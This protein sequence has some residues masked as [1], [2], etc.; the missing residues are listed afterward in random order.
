MKETPLVSIITPL[1]NSAAF[2][3]DALV[4]V[5]NQQYQ[6]WEHIIIDDC[7]EDNSLEIVERFSGKDARFKLIQLSKNS[8]S[9]VARN[10]GIKIAK[11]KYIAFIDS[12]DVWKE[13][14]LERQ[15]SF[16]Q[17]NNVL[18]SY[19]SYGYINEKG[20]VLPKTYHISGKHI[21]YTGL[22]KKTD[23]GCLTGMYNAETLGKFYMSEHR[24]KQ[25]YSLWLAI[26]KIGVVG[27]G[28]DE[29]LANY[30]L[31]KGS[32]TSSK[33]KLILYHIRFL[34]ETQGFNLIKASYYTVFWA[35]NGFVKYYLQ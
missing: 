4:S 27:F 10:E 13:E 3:E 8:G 33:Y 6:N 16:M 31:R 17:K 21:D 7:S 18:L 23:I 15:V 28:I 26:L 29:I 14:K 5:Q 12:D 35:Y 22:L 32:A 11:G 24:R 9:G 25:D 2:I 19:S 30:R 34:Q 20:G 1:Y